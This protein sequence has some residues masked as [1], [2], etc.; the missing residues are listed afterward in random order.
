MPKGERF[1]AAD[2]I[3]NILTEIVARRGEKGERRSVVHSDN[4]RLYT[5]KWQELFVIAISCELHDIH[6]IHGTYR[7]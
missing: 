1:T 5:A 6:V 3:R 2:Y 7:T 4:A